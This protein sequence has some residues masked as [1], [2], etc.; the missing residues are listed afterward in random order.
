MSYIKVK[1]DKYSVII[2]SYANMYNSSSED[3]YR[4]IRF[5]MGNKSTNTVGT[6]LYKGCAGNSSN[7]SEMLCLTTLR[8]PA[9]RVEYKAYIETL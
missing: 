1:Y 5:H 7:R 3:T 8:A 4:N 2:T 6:H 9:V